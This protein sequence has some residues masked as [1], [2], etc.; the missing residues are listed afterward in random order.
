MPSDP[1]GQEPPGSGHETNTEEG[2]VTTH[3]RNRDGIC[4][5]SNPRWEMAPNTRYPLGDFYE[6]W[7]GPRPDCR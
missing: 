1:G 5:T 3:P 7:G 4:I 2:D 6:P